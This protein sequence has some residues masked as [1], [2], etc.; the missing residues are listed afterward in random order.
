MHVELVNTVILAENF[1]ELRDWYAQVLD[2]TI[3]VVESGEE[4]LYAELM[5][6][7]SCIF[8]IA[9]AEQMGAKPQSPRQNTTLAQLCVPEIHELFERVQEH[10]GTAVFG[11]SYDEAFGGYYY[12]SFADPEGN[13]VWVINRNDFPVKG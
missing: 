7:N 8:G 1:A 6:G 10:N 4:Y 11:P 5:N 12:G 2:L 13:Q 9:D 3:N